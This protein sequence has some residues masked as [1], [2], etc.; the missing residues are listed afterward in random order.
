[1]I[2]TISFLICSVFGFGIKEMKKKSEKE[3]KQNIDN[4]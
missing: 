2:T 3:K 1:M 4:Q